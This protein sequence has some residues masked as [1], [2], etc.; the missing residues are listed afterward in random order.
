MKLDVILDLEIGVVLERRVIKVERYRDQALTVT[1]NQVQLALEVPNQLRIRDLVFEER[2]RA[3]MQ[4]SI[5]RLAVNECGVLTSESMAQIFNWER[6]FRHCSDASKALAK[7][8]GESLRWAVIAEFAQT[9]SATGARPP[10]AANDSKLGHSDR[11]GCRGHLGVHL[12]HRRLACF[13]AGHL[14]WFTK[15]GVNLDGQGDGGA[16]GRDRTDR[17]GKGS[18]HVNESLTHGASQPMRR[19]YS[20]V[21]L[22]SCTHKSR[23]C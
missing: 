2:E 7:L 5:A 12:N 20:F 21:F 13:R 17:S 16:Q 22:M 8:A 15:P 9:A 19:L 23:H 6:F 10:R 14:L 3:D 4:W 1:R 18:R 11:S